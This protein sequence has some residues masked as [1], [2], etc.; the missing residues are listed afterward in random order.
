M[1]TCHGNRSIVS[2]GVPFLIL[3]DIAAEPLAIANAIRDRVKKYTFTLAMV[4]IK[5]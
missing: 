1:L 5:D 3:E 2:A 4:S